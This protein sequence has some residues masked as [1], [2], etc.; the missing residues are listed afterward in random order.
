[1][2]HAVTLGQARDEAT[3]TRQQDADRWLAEVAQLRQALTV[4]QEQRDCA[5]QDRQEATTQIQAL[6]T[7]LRQLREETARLHHELETARAEMTVEHQRWQ[8]EQA[9]A[10][11]QFQQERVAL[12]E[13][14]ER[15]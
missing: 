12:Q 10:Q 7:E 3:A 6:D 4:S 8:E 9:T 15:G 14:V 1:R 11:Q 13:E 5:D 2:R